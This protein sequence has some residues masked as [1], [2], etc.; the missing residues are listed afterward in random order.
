MKPFIQC[1]N[2]E[3]RFRECFSF[4]FFLVAAFIIA[5]SITSLFI[6]EFWALVLDNVIL[7]TCLVAL[8]VY[9]NMK[10]MDEITFLQNFAAGIE[11]GAGEKSREAA[12]SMR[13]KKASQ[14]QNEFIGVISHELKTPIT[15]V[16]SGI[17]IIRSHGTNKF[18]DKQNKLLDIIGESGQE[19]LQLT[20][21]LLDI[22]KI[23]SGKIEIYPEHISL[24]SLIDEVIQSLK[25]EAEK[26]NIKIASMINEAVTT[27]YADPAR[28]KQILFNLLD[29]AIKYTDV[30]GSVSVA[31]SF[32]NN[33]IIIEVKDTGIGIKKERLGHIFSRFNEHAPGYKGTGLGLYI[34]KSLVEAHKGRI[35]VESELG[36]GSVFRIYFPKGP[37]A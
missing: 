5:L 12:S 3:K 21:D 34:A 23:E 13:Q 33:D 1:K 4:Q 22:S 8:L 27:I 28:M 20:N 30:N 25:P 9:L 24:A 36:K 29:N 11:Q 37:A 7:T 16:L 19:M 6:G 35:E 2:C 10:E 26:K 17:E 31:V 32:S 14:M 18:D 15:A